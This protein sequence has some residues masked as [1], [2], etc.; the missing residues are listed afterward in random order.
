M[1]DHQG[2]GHGSFIVGRSVYNQRIERWQDVF[3]VVLI[4][5][6]II[7]FPQNMNSYLILKM[8]SICFAFTMSLPRIN[9]PLTLFTG[10]LGTIMTCQA[11]VTVHQYNFGLWDSFKLVNTLTELK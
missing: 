5:F 9:N 1:T 11:Q 3:T 10:K 2:P 4:F 8:R 7:F 6:K